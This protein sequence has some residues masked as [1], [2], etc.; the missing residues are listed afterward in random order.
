MREPT[1]KRRT[2]AQCWKAHQPSSTPPGPDHFRF[3]PWPGACDPPAA[4]H[5]GLP[6]RP[7]LT[8]VVRHETLVVAATRSKLGRPERG[9]PGGGKQPRQRRDG[10]G[11]PD[12]PSPLARPGCESE[13]EAVGRV[14]AQ[15]WGRRAGVQRVT[16]APGHRHAVGQHGDHDARLKQPCGARCAHHIGW[17][18]G[19]EGRPGFALAPRPHVRSPTL[20]LPRRPAKA[21]VSIGP[22]PWPKLSRLAQRRALVPA[23]TPE[24]LTSLRSSTRAWCPRR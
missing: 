4:G 1:R 17:W 20:E 24:A 15:T 18:P 16:G 5:A 6:S 13:V 10:S 2:P 19:R 9:T 3:R 8:A 11:S 14:P 21:R 7:Y 23:T 22:L 12:G